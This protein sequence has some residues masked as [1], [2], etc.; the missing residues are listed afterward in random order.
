MISRFTESLKKSASRAKEFTE[1]EL[2]KKP[3][4]FLDFIEGL[5]A[6]AGSSHQLAHAQMNPYWLDIRDRLE[7][8]IE[9]GQS[10]PSFNNPNYALWLQISQSLLYLAEQG[11]KMFLKKAISVQK[12]NELLDVRLKNLPELKDSPLG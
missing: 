2:D 4:L 1:V 10:L 7:K 5:K 9:V 3:A 11:N 6:A 8:I 12:V